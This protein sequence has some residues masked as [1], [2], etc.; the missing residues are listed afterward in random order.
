M[1][2]QRDLFDE[3]LL[4][5]AWLAAGFS[6][7]TVRFVLRAVSDL[8]LRKRCIPSR[9]EIFRVALDY[10]HGLSNCYWLARQ[11]VASI[12]YGGVNLVRTRPAAKPHERPS[13]A[14]EKVRVPDVFIRK[15]IAIGFDS[16]GDKHRTDSVLMPLIERPGA[17][18]Y[19][20]DLAKISNSTAK[21][22]R[23]S[24]DAQRLDG[25]AKGVNAARE[26][27]FEG[28]GDGLGMIHPDS[29][30]MAARLKR[31][32]RVGL[33]AWKPPGSGNASSIGV[34]A[35]NAQAAVEVMREAGWTATVAIVC[36]GAV[37]NE[38]PDGNGAWIRCGMRFDVAG[39][40]DIGVH[41]SI[42]SPGVCLNVAVEPVSFMLLMD[43]SK[44][45]LPDTARSRGA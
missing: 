9:G 42:A 14:V 32:R 5:Y 1:R 8:W 6:A 27:F 43:A 7:G 19:V 10:E 11:D 20:A 25:L 39:G 18:Q 2:R 45:R 17:K 41:P 3:I 44:L 30:A 29:L 13:V 26:T 38:C 31:S 4:L 40:S 23:S 33:L 22:L 21:S 16:L 15:H 24:D 12:I 35:R 34:V 36:G 37:L 28:W